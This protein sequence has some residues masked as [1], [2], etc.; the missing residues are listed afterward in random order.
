LS[1]AISTPWF[2]NPE[3]LGDYMEVIGAANPDEIW[4]VDN[5]SNPPLEFASIR[6]EEN[7]GFCGGSNAGLHAATTDIVVFLN[8]D[9]ALI[10]RDWLE[11]LLSPL[12]LGV[13]V[14]AQLRRDRHAYVDGQ[15]MPYLDGWCLAGM[16]TDLLELGGFDE[17]LAEPAYF[18]DNLH[19]LEAR[20]A[21]MTLCAAPTV[22][23]R[24]K[25]NATV[26][27]L[28]WSQAD[29]ATRANMARYQQRARELLKVAA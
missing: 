22:G 25:G 17:T 18:S 24:H 16:R 10:A 5:G 6:L 3:L 23:L 26:R 27:S 19:C 2:E 29:R 9:V 21:G 28:P 14:G 13:L 11:R 20:A 7:C 12:E 8:S 4:I 1:V 15:E